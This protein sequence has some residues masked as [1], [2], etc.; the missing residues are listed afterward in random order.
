MTVLGE[1]TDP[2]GRSVE[3]TSERWEHIVD[4]ELDGHP[5]LARYRAEV[6]RAVSEPDESRLGRRRNERWYFLRG[7]GPSRWLQVV[8]AFEQE[9]GWIV[10]AFAPRRDP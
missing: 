1:V 4:D 7:A 10:T 6:L 2:D 9:R 3:L 5:E 8:V